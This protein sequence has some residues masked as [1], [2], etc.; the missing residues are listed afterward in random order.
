MTGTQQGAILSGGSDNGNCMSG[1]G[2]TP[3]GRP[4]TSVHDTQPTPSATTELIAVER[5]RYSS[6]CRP[7]KIHCTRSVLAKAAGCAAVLILLVAVEGPLQ[8]D[9]L[10]GHEG[11]TCHASLFEVG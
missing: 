9:S 11:K 10:H 8:V 7:C 1:P 3:T 4:H 2:W 6:P 5:Q